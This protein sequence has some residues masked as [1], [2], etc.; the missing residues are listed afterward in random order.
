[1]QLGDLNA[2]D[3]R[4]PYLDTFGVCLEPNGCFLDH[5]LESGDM[6]IDVE[7]FVPADF[8]ITPDVD[9]SVLQP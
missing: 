5:K 2:L 4:C 9:Y 8:E 1:M 6:R 7:P 3:S